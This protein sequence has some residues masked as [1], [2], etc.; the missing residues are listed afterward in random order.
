MKLGPDTA[1]EWGGIDAQH[2]SGYFYD[3]TYIDGFSHVRMHG[4]GVPD[5]GNLGVMPVLGVSDATRTEKGRR[6]SFTHADETVE[7]GRYAVVLGN[8]IKVELTST[9]R[10]AHRHESHSAA[11]PS[12]AKAR[13]GIR[14]RGPTNQPPS[15]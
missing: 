11:R 2:C 9:A 1:L 13:P 7:P 8:G 3:D 15:Q 12:A 4:T 5:Y 6:A 14:W 10:A